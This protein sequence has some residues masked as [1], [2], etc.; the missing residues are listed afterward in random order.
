MDM[1]RNDSH[2]INLRYQG[3]FEWG[4][5]QARAYHEKTRHGMNFGE[6]KQF[7]YGAKSDVPGMPMDT[8]PSCL[9]CCASAAI[10]SRGWADTRKQWRFIR[11]G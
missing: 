11:K 2:Q 7:W 9:R 10:V 6:D 8:E 3:Q 1:A 4:Q 5:L